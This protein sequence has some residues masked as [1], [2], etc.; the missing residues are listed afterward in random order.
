MAT[1]KV[2]GK[3][4]EN[5]KKIK[6][7]TDTETTVDFVDTSDATATASDITSGKSAYVNGEIVVGTNTRTEPNDLDG[8]IDGTITNFVMP[9]GKTIISPYRF[10]NF[11][12][13]N[14]INLGGVK[15]IGDYAFYE[16]KNIDN[17]VQ[18]PATI[19][20]IGD[21]AMYSLGSNKTAF[22]FHPAELCTIGS[23]G[24]SHSKI[25]KIIGKF[26]LGSSAFRECRN[27]TEIDAEFTAIGDY[28]FS[29][30]SSLATI[31]MKVNGEIGSSV[32]SSLYNA[33]TVEISPDS[34]VTSLGSSC[35]N[36][37]GSK[38]ANPEIN[39][40]VFDFSKST[41]TTIPQHSFGTSST[42]NK[43]RYMKLTFPATVDKIEQYAFRYSDNC[44]YYFTSKTP[45]TLS[46]TTSWDNATNYKIF[47]PFSSINAYKT[48]SNWTTQTDYMK[49]Y[50]PA[51]TFS[52]GYTLPELNVEGYALTWYS[53]KA[54][55]TQV[56]TVT[57]KNAELYCLA[58]DEKLGYG[59]KSISAYNCSIS[60]TD[61]NGK[62]YVAGEGVRTGTILTI[63]G[64][65][66]IE[67][68]VPY[69]FKVNDTDFV[70]GSTLTVSDDISV[71]AIYWDGVNLPINPTFADNL[72]TIIF[73][74]FRA[75]TASGIWN[76]GDTKPFTS[77]SGKNYTLRIADMTAGRY[78][79]ADGSGTTNGVLEFVELYNLNGTTRWKINNTTKEGQWT[80]GG[81][82]MSD[83][84]NIYLQQIFDDL[85][86]DLQSAISEITLNEYSYTS[87]SPRSGNHRLFLPAET[88]MFDAR[89]NS[90]EGYQS[91]CPKYTQFGYY[92]QNN[93]NAAR[94]KY[95]VG[96]TSN[97]EYWLRSPMSNQSNIFCLVKNGDYRTGYAN[98]AAGAAPCF[99]I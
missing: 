61:G 4:Y 53:D 65:P 45:P 78:N 42:S 39:I 55:T 49:G 60:I 7:K 44:E 70:S 73:S 2:D 51:G 35:F 20:K 83:M 24:Y 52:V 27:L 80:G 86:D 67:G 68:Y 75:G 92:A 11:T 1:L 46:A 9:N 58:G 90:A 28:A 98:G 63:T 3:V 38:R 97:S 13:L 72:W 64:T 23:Y 31:K 18:L 33:N 54:C 87:P 94:T 14:S 48:A 29:N 15:E 6:A 89:H 47:V 85:P 32:F 74:A 40:I 34:V 77:K 10:Y 37:L 76:V 95:N 36:G 93:T 26:S 22:Q 19:T 96:T 57:D 69:M 59:I 16:C 66:T 56:T 82:A 30:C 50:A 17:I 8:I 84:A 43:N 25:S 99:A 5:V 91:G 88:E 12:S 62:S 71:T 41:F 21:Y 79:L 81:Y